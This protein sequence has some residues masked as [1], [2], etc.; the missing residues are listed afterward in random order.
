[1]SFSSQLIERRAGRGFDG[2]DEANKS[3][4]KGD[5]NPQL[6]ISPARFPEPSQLEKREREKKKEE[7]GSPV[8]TVGMMGLGWFR[9]K[10]KYW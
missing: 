6:P 2:A 8:G 9:E 3:T 10:K 7:F 5:I 4:A 1:M